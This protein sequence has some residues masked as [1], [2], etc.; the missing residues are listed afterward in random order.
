MIEE[1]KN[2][3]LKLME[4]LFERLKSAEIKH[5]D[6]SD[7]IYQGV[8]VIG[9]EYGEL[10]QALNKGQGDERV[11]DEALDLLCVVWRFCRGDWEKS[12]QE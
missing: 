9:E 6:F 11:M 3:D 12:R 2:P 7:G 1:A 5:P 4:A 8:G 10:C